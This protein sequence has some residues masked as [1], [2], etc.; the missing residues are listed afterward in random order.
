MAKL[1][2]IASTGGIRE[3]R[4]RLPIRRPDR[5][6]LGCADGARDVT[7]VALLCGNG[8]DLAARLEGSARTSRRDRRVAQLVADLHPTRQQCRDLTFELDGHGGV[9]TGLEIVKPNGSELLV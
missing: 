8:D 7:R 5:R 6:P 3:V 4:Q 1:Q 9:G 2:L